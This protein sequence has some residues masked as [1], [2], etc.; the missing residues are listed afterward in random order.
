MDNKE[1]K[2]KAEEIKKLL[3]V[4][5]EYKNKSTEVILEEIYKKHM[6]KDERE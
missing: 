4:K 3:K 6:H 2:K 1:Q 5:K